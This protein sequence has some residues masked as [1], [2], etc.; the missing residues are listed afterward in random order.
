M[1]RYFF[2]LSITCQKSVSMLGMFI[3]FSLILQDDIKKSVDQACEHLPSSINETCVAFVNTYGD[4]IVA[5]LAQ[6]IDPSVV[7]PLVR[8]CPSNKDSIEVFM[9]AKP[10]KPNCPLCLLAV[11]KL[12][13]VVTN[14]HSKQSIRDALASLCNHLSGS[15]KAEC[16]DFVNT[17]SDELVEMLFTDFTP[18]EICVYLKLCTDKT[19]A[20]TL[21][22]MPKIT[23]ATFT[24]PTTTTECKC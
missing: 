17:Y 5:I 3:N 11:T 24:T 13:E 18:Q 22:P 1:V 8:A 12:E 6:E 15:I 10:E 21:P 9:Q 20:P 16:V 23:D 19:P 4:A 14:K 2:C 7:C